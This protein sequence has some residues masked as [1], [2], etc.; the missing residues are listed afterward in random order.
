MSSGKDSGI[1][2][3]TSGTQ[4]SLDQMKSEIQAKE[5]EKKVSS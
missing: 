5:N 3:G 4:S 2:N 1:T